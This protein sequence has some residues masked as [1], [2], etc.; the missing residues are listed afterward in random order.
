MKVKIYTDGSCKGNPGPGKSLAIIQYNDKKYRISKCHDN[1]TNNRAEYNALI[2]ALKELDNL[3]FSEA[4]IYTDSKLIWGHLTQNW[5]V[6]KN[7][8]L[9]NEAKNLLLRL[10]E[11][12]IKVK[13][14]WVPRD[15]N[16]A[17]I[18]LENE[19]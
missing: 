5:K 19:V 12:S 3:D 4:I 15:I 13:I 8:D 18:E 17:G 14:E 11:K 6:N 7:Q 2:L 1:T 9:V 10:S 16:E